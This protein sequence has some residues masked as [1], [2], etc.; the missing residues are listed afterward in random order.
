MPWTGEG[1]VSSSWEMTGEIGK[2]HVPA[3]WLN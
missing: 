2:V 1:V 3:A